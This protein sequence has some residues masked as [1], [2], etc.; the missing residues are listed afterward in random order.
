MV[1]PMMFYSVTAQVAIR[2]AHTPTNGRFYLDPPDGF[3][4]LL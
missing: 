3:G 2:A 1:W 4:N